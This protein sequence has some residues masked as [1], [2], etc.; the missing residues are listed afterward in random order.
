[1]NSIT[2]LFSWLRTLHKNLNMTPYQK[3]L[4]F[5]FLQLKHGLQYLKEVE[6]FILIELLAVIVILAIITL[7]ATPIILGIINNAR[8]QAKVRTAELIAKET[9]LAYTSYLFKN[10]GQGD[11]NSFCDYMTEEFFAMDNGEIGT[12]EDGVVT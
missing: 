4:V 2:S 12:C 11:A 8:E 5:L 1:M 9:E 10:N 3:Q 6:S 7:I